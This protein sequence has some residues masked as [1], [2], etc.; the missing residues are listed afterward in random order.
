[1]KWICIAHFLF[2]IFK[3][4]LQSAIK[5]CW[6]DRT[7]A[8]E[9]AAGSHYHSI[10]D[11]TQP[12]QPM[13]V[14]DTYVRTDHRTGNSVPYSLQLVGGFFNIPQAYTILYVCTEELWDRAFRLSSSSKKTSKSN[15]FQM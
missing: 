15:D 7:S 4:T 9:G 11:L 10:S 8:Y 5:S 3:C 1:M 13:N 12:T 2:S 14:G 6:L